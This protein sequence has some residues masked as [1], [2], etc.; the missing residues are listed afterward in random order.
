[1]KPE[2]SLPCAQ[3]SPLFPI[4]LLSSKVTTFSSFKP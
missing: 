1:M 4:K 3:D 2:D